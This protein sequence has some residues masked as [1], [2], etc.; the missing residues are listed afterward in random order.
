MRFVRSSAARTAAGP[1]A[2][3][4]AFL[5]P[6]IA[7]SLEAA[8]LPAPGGLEP[9][10]SRLLGG[11]IYGISATDPVT[12]VGVPAILGLV[13]LVANYLPARAATRGDPLAA[14]RSD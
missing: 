2:F 4:V 5:A 9:I 1:L 8:S 6:L 3:G 14:L 11:V 12:F 13:A 7:Q 10:L